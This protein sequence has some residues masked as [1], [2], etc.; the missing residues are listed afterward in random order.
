MPAPLALTPYVKRFANPVLMHLAGWGWFVELEHVGRRTG[1]TYRTPL[2]AFRDGDAV[3]IALTYG[4]G[5]QWLKNIRAAGR[6]RMRHRGQVLELGEP[7]DL[8]TEDGLRRMPRPIRFVFAR[9]GAVTDFVELPILTER[10][11]RQE[12]S[13]R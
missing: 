7:V 2:L 10:L 12:R 4:P 11:F 1:T 13:A 6:S 8:S 3:T 9:T 5:V